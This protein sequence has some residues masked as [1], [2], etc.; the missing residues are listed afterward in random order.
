MGPASA[1]RQVARHPE[2]GG[3][4]TPLSSRIGLPGNWDLQGLYTRDDGLSAGRGQENLLIQADN[5]IALRELTTLTACKVRCVYLDPP[6]NNQESYRHYEDKLSHQE[7]LARLI[8]RL[9]TI[10]PL[11]A[12]NG[13]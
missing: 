7:W 12:P 4:A 8:E 6:Y 13:S 9:R 5:L 3:V 11:L 2:T 10:P 1:A